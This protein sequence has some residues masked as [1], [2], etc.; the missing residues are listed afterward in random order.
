MSPPEKATKLTNLSVPRM[1]DTYISGS[2]LLYLGE[3]KS[4]LL[5]QS[6]WL[7][8]FDP[9]NPALALQVETREPADSVLALCHPSGPS[10][11]AKGRGCLYPFFRSATAQTSIYMYRLSWDV[12][13]SL[14]TLSEPVSR[15]NLWLKSPTAWIAA[16]PPSLYPIRPHTVTWTVQFNSF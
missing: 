16:I 11:S 8:T 6:S 4:L 1:V 3:E 9:F 13:M 14:I 12:S 15:E 7:A 5:Q 2:Q 10:V